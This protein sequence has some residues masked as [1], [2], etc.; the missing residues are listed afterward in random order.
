MP[1]LGEPLGGTGDYE[2]LSQGAEAVRDKS[3]LSSLVPG[4]GQK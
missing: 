2:L 4:P 3:L 1:D